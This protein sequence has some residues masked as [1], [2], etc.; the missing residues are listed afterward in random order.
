MSNEDCQYIFNDCVLNARR[1]AIH[2]I[3]EITGETHLFKEL[4]N[5]VIS[6]SCIC[7]LTFTAVD[8]DEAG[9]DD[10]DVVTFQAMVEFPLLPSFGWHEL[11]HWR[12][13]ETA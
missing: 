5:V 10:A 13:I 2:K 8:A 6:T 12:I 4:K 7:L 9:A 1:F 11:L 3:N